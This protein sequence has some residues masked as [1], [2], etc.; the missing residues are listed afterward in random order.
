LKLTERIYLI[1]GGAYGYSATGD[2]N[3]YVIDCNGSL[4]LIDTG[5]GNGIPRVIDNIRNMSFDPETLE[6]AFITHCHYDHIGGNKAMKIAT[7]C[8]IAAHE[9]EKEEIENLGKLT[10]YQ[11]GQE[12]GLS[13]EPT[14]VDITLKGGEKM[15]VGDVEFEIVHTPG[16]SPGGISLVI[17]EQ[18]ATNLFPGDTASAQGKL[19]F[20]NGPGFSLEEWK[21]SIKRMLNIK[22]E[23]MFPGHGVFVISEAVEHLRVYDAKINAPWINVVTSIG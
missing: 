15:H 9:N 6:V 13:F 8:R 3:M 11:M 19:G 17:R 5:G 2:C 7:G 20:I 1:G 23:K 4:A 12:N 10:L 22:P 18:G 21:K 14:E 16:H